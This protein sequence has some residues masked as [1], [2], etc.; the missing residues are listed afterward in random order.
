[1]RSNSCTSRVVLRVKLLWVPNHD[2][3]YTAK[4]AN[5][6]SKSNH[7]RELYYDD[8]HV[9]KG[10]KSL[11]NRVHRGRHHQWLLCCIR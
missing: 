2:G 7:H 10:I 1:M 11:E 6:Y 8:C 3:C 9:A 5:L 4:A